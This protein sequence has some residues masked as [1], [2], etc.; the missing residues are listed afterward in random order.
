L[1]RLQIVVGVGQRDD[2]QKQ[3]RYGEGRTH[4]PT[5]LSEV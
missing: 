5:S 4:D 3:R 1:T 2:G